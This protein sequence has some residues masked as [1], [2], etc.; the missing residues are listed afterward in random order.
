[1]RSKSGYEDL[2]QSGIVPIPSSATLQR[3]TKP[4]KVN[5]WF[6]PKMNYLID[7][8][9]EIKK[10]GRPVIGHLMMDEIKLKTEYYG[11][12]LQMLWQDL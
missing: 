12:L 9:N 8:E 3:L 4:F 2:K 6:G 1:M 11:T 10:H 7:I 5:E